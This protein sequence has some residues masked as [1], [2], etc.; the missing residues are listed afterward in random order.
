MW[1]N[2]KQP[3]NLCEHFLCCVLTIIMITTQDLYFICSLCCILNGYGWLM[4]FKKFFGLFERKRGGKT[5]RNRDGDFPYADLFPTC[6]QQLRLGQAEARTWKLILIL[7]CGKQGP[8]CL[9]HYM[10]PPKDAHWEETRIKPGL[11]LNPGTLTWDVSVLIG[12]SAT[13]QILST[14]LFNHSS[15]GL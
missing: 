10:K 8:N 5:D 6:P 11:G 2:L 4:S 7:P 3:L 14:S 13:S 9:S 1:F 15:P 12:I